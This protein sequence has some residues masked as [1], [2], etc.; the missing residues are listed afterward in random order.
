MRIGII[1][2]GINGA[3]LGWKLSRKND[4]TIFEQKRKIG[5]E[6]CSGLVSERLW[7]FI[8]KNKKLIKNTINSAILHYPNKDVKLDFSP[9]IFVLEHK[10]LDRYVVSLAKKNNIKIFLNKKVTKVTQNK[11][12]IIYARKSFEFDYVI[13]CD[14]ALSI[15][16]KS[17]GIE[18]PKY[19]LG[20]LTY[21][22][23]KD[24]SDFFET[25][26][27][28]HGF[29]WR[30]PRGSKVEY[31]I[32]ERTDRAK[33]MF[34]SFLKKKKIKTRKIYSRVIP[35]G[36]TKLYKGKIALTGDACG[37]TKPWSGG[38]IIWGLL[39][40]DI[41]LRTFPNFR[42]YEN[43]VRRLFEA[44]IF[45]SNLTASLAFKISK[46]PLPRKYLFDSDWVF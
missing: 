44:N 8:P 1:G 45:F 20:M 37:L 19:R 3:Y 6:V 22:N 18:D 24:K 39:A 40:D 35:L 4:V 29:F 28:K 42:K 5:K 30:I 25:W 38:G 12:P 43:E 26:P 11:K 34:Q 13:G 2:C 31:G 46:L 23:K 33:R 15:T 16:R 21:V 14:G 7:N 27:T 36:L 32:L 10:L 17:L 41:L 9:K